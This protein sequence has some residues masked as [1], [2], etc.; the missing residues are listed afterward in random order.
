MQL[1]LNPPSPCFYPWLCTLGMLGHIVQMLLGTHL[2][3]GA[4]RPI[5]LVGLMNQGAPRCLHYTLILDKGRVPTR[6]YV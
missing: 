6:Q 4:E 2:M 1:V 5:L 3:V